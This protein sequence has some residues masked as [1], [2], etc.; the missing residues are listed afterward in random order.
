MEYIWLELYKRI[1]DILMI[2]CPFRKLKQR[3]HVTPW[4]TA[5]IYKARRE[6]DTLIKL[7][8]Q[9][10][11]SLYLVEARRSRNFVNGLMQKAKSDYIQRQLHINDKNPKKF[12]RIIKDLLN[13][14]QNCT[15]NARFIDQNTLTK[16]QK[17]DEPDFLN[18]Y[19]INIVR[20]LHVPENDTVMDTV[21]NVDSVFTFEENMPTVEEVL[22]LIREIDI[23]KS[24]RVDKMN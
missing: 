12:W 19:F 9:T 22:N 14:Q 23:N 4:M 11:S 6:R 3:K 15:V 5:L 13:P 10:R 1:Y 20:N 2:M 17:G 18:D 24:S 7:F 8:K 21:Y 16:V